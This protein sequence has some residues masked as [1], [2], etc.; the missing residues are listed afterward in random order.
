MKSHL[1]DTL[2]KGIVFWVDM[3]SWMGVWW[4]EDV[5]GCGGGYFVLFVCVCCF[6]VCVSD[7]MQH[8]SLS[9]C[10]VCCSLSV[11][12]AVWAEWCEK[13]KKSEL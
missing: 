4:W 1:F 2:T 13:K 11:L 12:W 7:V 6:V 9:L 3:T 5:Y 8:L 10:C